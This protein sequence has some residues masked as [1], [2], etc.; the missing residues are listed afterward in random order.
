MRGQSVRRAFLSRP[1]RSRITTERG[2]RRLAAANADRGSRPA[3]ARTSARPY[4]G[5]QLC[6][7]RLAADLSELIAR[8]CAPNREAQ[9]PSASK[10][11]GRTSRSEIALRAEATERVQS[12]S[13]LA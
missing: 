7:S 3:D 1:R 11:S 13:L 6:G 8:R 10:G 4:R 9:Y 2:L 5:F 12:P